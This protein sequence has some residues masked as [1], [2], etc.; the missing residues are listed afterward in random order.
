MNLRWRSKLLGL[1]ALSFFVSPAWATASQSPQWLLMTSFWTKHFDPKPEHN[2]HQDMINLEYQTAPSEA[3]F[4]W[5]PA[6][7]DIRYLAGAATF[8]NSF[9]QRSEYA[10][11]G[12]TQRWWGSDQWDIY[13]KL[14]MGLLHGYRG[15]Y[16]D[17]IPL[18]GWGTAP[19]V[20]PGVGASWGPVSTE[21][22]LFGSAGIM[23]TGGVRF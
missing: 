18:N 15:E 9:A 5:L 12:V 8:R 21:V 4:D 2:N 14:T 11:V 3:P 20:L 22:I 7:P 19:A 10:Y 1:V 13:G 16:K 6:Q 17:K 23:W